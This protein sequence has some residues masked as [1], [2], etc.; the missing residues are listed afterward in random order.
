MGLID[1]IKT[2]DFTLGVWRVEEPEEKLKEI[3]GGEY[4]P[5]LNK[6]SHPRRRL[7]W[8]AARSLLRE[9]GYLGLVKYH[10]TR[11][12]FLADSL[13]HISIS[14]SFPFVSVILSNNFLVGI[15]VEYFDRPFLSVAHKYLSEK[16]KTWVNI[17]DNKMLALI[18]SAKEALYKLPGMEG[19]GGVDMD[20][21][22]IESISNKGSL[23][24]NIRLGGTVQHFDYIRYYYIGSFNLVWVCC[25]PKTL[26]W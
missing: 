9:F 13:A 1:I 18:W 8:L 5:S 25:N 15:D 17:N 3:V 4:F 10:P 16:E 12:P 19:L 20:I 22:Q 14:H 23:Y 7:E 21:R 2:D 11:R 6:I 24:A 26:V